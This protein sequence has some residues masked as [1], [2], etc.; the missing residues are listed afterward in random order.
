MISL[1]GYTDR[2]SARPGESLAVKVSSSLDKPYF[3]DL[4]RIHSADPNPAGP[5][6]RYTPA[7]A[8][9]AGR[10]P[11]RAQAIHQGSCGVVPIGSLPLGPNW[12]IGLRVQP[13]LLEG[14]ES[15]VLSAGGATPLS[16][17]V[18]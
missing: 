6:M 12:T 8:G 11:S 14:R 7:Q 3:A 13:W 5:G 16:L 9:F 4:V 15:A 10:Y 2:F 1:V 17:R 18:S